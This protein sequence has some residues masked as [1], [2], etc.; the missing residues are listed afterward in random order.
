MDLDLDVVRSGAGPVALVDEDEFVA[1]AARYAYPATLVAAARAA[2]D[3]LLALARRGAAPF[4]VQ[5]G[6]TALAALAAQLR[7]DAP[8]PY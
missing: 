8:G 6:A 4:I 1:H 5:D 2:A 3:N 7:R